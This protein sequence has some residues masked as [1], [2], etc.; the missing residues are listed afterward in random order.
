MRNWVGRESVTGGLREIVFFLAQ[1]R[2]FF[3]VLLGVLVSVLCHGCLVLSIFTVFLLFS[4]CVCV[5]GHF[6]VVC[7][8]VGVFRVSVLVMTGIYF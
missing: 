6:C 1:G 3:F 5:C 7:V 2:L 8:S 4:A